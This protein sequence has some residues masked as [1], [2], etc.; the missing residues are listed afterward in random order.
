VVEIADQGIAITSGNEAIVADTQVERK[1]RLRVAPGSEPEFEVSRRFRFPQFEVPTAGQTIPVVY[2]PSD[3][4]KIMLDE[5]RFGG[6]RA[7]LAADGFDPDQLSGEVDDLELAELDMIEGG[8]TP[9]EY[10]DED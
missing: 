2:D 1:V 10:H 7:T 5:S 9:T 8:Q 4:D 3:H 6:Q